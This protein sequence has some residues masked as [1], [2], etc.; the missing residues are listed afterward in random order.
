MKKPAHPWS[1][2]SGAKINLMPHKTQPSIVKRLAVALPLIAVLMATLAGGCASPVKKFKKGDLSLSYKNKTT[3][4]SEVEAQLLAHPVK[5][6]RKTVSRHL[7]ALVY[8]HNALFSKGEP[9]FTAKQVGEIYKILTKAL[10]KASPKKIVYFEVDSQEGTTACELFATDEG[11]NWKFDTI[12][13]VDYSKNMLKGWGS[14]W[15]MIPG[16]GQ[17]FYLSQKLLGKKVWENW[18]VAQLDLPESDKRKAAKKRKVKKTSKKKSAKKKTQQSVQDN[19]ELEKKLR[20]LKDLH[21]KGLIDDDEY[22][23]ERKRLLDQH[24]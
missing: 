17:E 23:D 7:L 12:H 20:I 11:L 1:L 15:R 5:I 24:F 13:G 14:T 16:K 6:S 21:K 19:P 4:L 9:V 3:S 22:K 10:N 8:S 2:K 18:I